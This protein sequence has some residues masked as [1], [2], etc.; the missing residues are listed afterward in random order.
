[1]FLKYCVLQDNKRRVREADFSLLD[2]ASVKTSSNE[3]VKRCPSPG[4][5]CTRTSSRPSK[6]TRVFSLRIVSNRSSTSTGDTVETLRRRLS[7]VRKPK[8]VSVLGDKSRK[9][10]YMGRGT[11]SSDFLSSR[12]L[13]VSRIDVVVLPI[14]KSPKRAHKSELS[15]SGLRDHS[16]SRSTARNEPA[17]PELKVP[18]AA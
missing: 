6:M 7:T 8:S 13:R 5:R 3:R 12:S 14:P 1:M 18:T 11:C 16:T 15:F 9:S 10:K 4:D 2:S 17:V